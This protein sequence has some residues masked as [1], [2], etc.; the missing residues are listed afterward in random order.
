MANST[1]IAGDRASVRRA[2]CPS[3]G[4]VNQSRFSTEMAIHFPGLKNVNKPT[5]WV[6]P[7]VLVCLDCGVSEFTVPET[8]LR[9]F[10]TGEAEQRKE[11]PLG[12]SGAVVLAPANREITEIRRPWGTGASCTVSNSVSLAAGLISCVRSARLSSALPPQN[13]RLARRSSSPSKHSE[14]G[15]ASR[16]TGFLLLEPS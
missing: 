10:V 14:A 4:S 12:S 16:F 2:T 11:L 8:E 13:P 5:V 3:C 15:G 6:F 1:V 7:E 9:V